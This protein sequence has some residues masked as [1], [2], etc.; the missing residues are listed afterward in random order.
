MT[1]AGLQAR[2]SLLERNTLRVPG[3]SDWLLTVTREPQIVTAL[4]WADREG[5]PVM[6]MGGG[7]NLVLAADYPGLVLLMDLRERRWQ[8]LNV[9]GEAPFDSAILSLGAGE[10]WDSVV[11][12]ACEAGYRGLENLALIPG[13]VGAAP[14]Q[15]IGAYG[16]ELSQVLLDVTAF[17][18]HKGD[19]VTLDAP[20]CR[21]AYRDS[22][23]KQSPERYIITRVRLR[24]SRRGP[25][26]LG[27]GELAKALEP[28]PE[29]SLTPLLVAGT[30]TRLR[31]SKLPDPATLPNAGSFFKN[32]VV[33][34]AHY[35]RLLQQEPELVAFPE[36]DRYK[37]AAGWLIQRCG[38]KGYRNERVGVHDRQALV[39]VNHG[40]G[41]GADILALAERIR[42]DVA[43]RFDVAL[44]IEPRILG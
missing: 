23:F 1:P 21:F 34:S 27:Y 22:L 37:L 12:H 31:Q 43:R 4:E 36:G 13:T 5:L 15:N 11:R 10:N 30:I 44:E 24:L 26:R 28:V 17:D 39:L 8:A 20:Q 6:V 33:D 19:F 40:G 29:S 32:P 9:P 7:S 42:E 18:R 41:N 2:A 38:W 14:V 25:F 35:Q 16:A 3:R